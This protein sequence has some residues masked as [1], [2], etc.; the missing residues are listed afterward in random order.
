MTGKAEDVDGG[1]LV[2]S[3]TDFDLSLIFLSGQNSSVIVI[4][5][6]QDAFGDTN[7]TLWVEDPT[8]LKDSHTFRINIYPYTLPGTF[9]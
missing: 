8:G 6:Q 1:E 9:F 2:W 4:H 7:A 5:G 3:L